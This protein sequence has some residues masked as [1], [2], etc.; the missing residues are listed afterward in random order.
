M[1][2]QE[3]AASAA[4]D[5]DPDSTLASVLATATTRLAPNA[6]ATVFVLSVGAV[7]PAGGVPVA[8]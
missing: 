8:C 2:A 5:A 1:S 7:I 4:I 6:I 3:C